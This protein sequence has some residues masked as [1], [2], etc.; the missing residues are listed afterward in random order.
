MEKKEQYLGRKVPMEL[1]SEIKIIAAETNRNVQDVILD[2]FVYYARVEKIKI[3]ARK[4]AVFL[5]KQRG[6][7]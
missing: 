2:A 1:A 3:A 4:R 5:R 6:G 7:K